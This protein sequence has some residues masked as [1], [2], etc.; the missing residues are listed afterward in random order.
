VDTAELRKL[1]DK[2]ALSS[3][4]DWHPTLEFV[5]TWVLALRQA[6][7]ELD[8]LKAHSES[9]VQEFIDHACQMERQRDEA[10]AELDHYKTFHEVNTAHISKLDHRLARAIEV[11]KHY[12]V[13]HGHERIDDTKWAREALKELESA[14]KACAPTTTSAPES[15]P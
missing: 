3:H 11:L 7:D 1:A 12:A 2:A 4:D 8:R 10:R 15:D 9:W 6:A 14:A 13:L 5:Q